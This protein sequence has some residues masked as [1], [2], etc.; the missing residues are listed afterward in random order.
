MVAPSGPTHSEILMVG[1]A[2]GNEEIIKGRAFIGNTGDVL[3]DEMAKVGMSFMNVRATNLWLHPK[4]ESEF[5]FHMSLLMR[6]MEGKKF[7]MLMG[8]ELAECFDYAPVT[9]AVGLQVHSPM[10]PKGSFVMATTN[11]AIVFHRPV[12]EFRLSLQKFARRIKH[13]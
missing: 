12:G 11:P 9:D 8:S 10:F 13:D 2:P 5:D 3:A 6:E 4:R 7:I 1:E